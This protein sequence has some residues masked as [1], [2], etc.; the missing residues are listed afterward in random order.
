MMGQNAPQI[1][2]LFQST[3]FVLMVLKCHFYEHVVLPKKAVPVCHFWW[4]H[5]IDRSRNPASTRLLVD[6]KIYRDLTGGFWMSRESKI[7]TRFLE[8]IC[9]CLGVHLL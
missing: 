5:L 1:T 4:K 6:P 9:R 8:S 7:W 2:V 3:I